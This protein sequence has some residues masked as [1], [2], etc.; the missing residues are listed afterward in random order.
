MS[1]L[2]GRRLLSDPVEE[3]DATLR[4]FA[5][6]NRVSEGEVR[7]LAS[8]NWRGDPPKTIERWRFVYDALKASKSLDR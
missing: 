6:A 3:I 1:A 7:T 2:L 4:K 5:K 8:I